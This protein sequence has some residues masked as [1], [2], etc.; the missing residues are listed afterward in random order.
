MDARLVAAVSGSLEGL[1]VAGLCRSLGIS[2]Q[3]FYKWRAR[4]GAEGLEGLQE[5]SRA[6]GAAP[7]GSRPR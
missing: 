5:R 3:S 1:N 2:R 4:Y 7:T 6:P